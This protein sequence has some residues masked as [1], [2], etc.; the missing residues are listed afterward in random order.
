MATDGATIPTPE[1][2]AGTNIGEIV[3]VVGPVVD[4]RFPPEH[5]P[6]IL[7][8][9][10]IQQDGIDLTV[11]VSQMRGDDVV[12]CVAMSSTDGIVRG[13][14]AVDTGG[15]I[16]VP[17]GRGTLGRVYDLLGNPIDE[18]GPSATTESWPIHRPAPS[19]EDQSAG[20]EILETGM[21]VID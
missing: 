3:A 13:M 5:L 19:F 7:N 4:I 21:K 20:T 10:K 15:P 8:A 9:L 6:E 16:M 1:K 2:T 11:E 17:V 14:K 12:R 18:R